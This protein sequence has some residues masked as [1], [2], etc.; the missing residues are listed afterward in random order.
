MHIQIE[1]AIGLPMSKGRRRLPRSQ[2][3]LRRLGKN[4]GVLRQ[5]LGKS[6]LQILPIVIT[7]VS[8]CVCV[9]M[10]VYSFCVNVCCWIAKLL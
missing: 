4:I 6:A 2:R 8:R 1:H 9:C 5:L 10:Y 7:P 3:H